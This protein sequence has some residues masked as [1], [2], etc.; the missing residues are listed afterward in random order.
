M[1]LEPEV[2]VE[3][4]C[5]V[6]LDDED[7]CPVAPAT[8]LVERLGR[9]RRVSLAPVLPQAH[10]WRACPRACLGIERLDENMICKRPGFT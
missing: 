1:A 2:I 5:V 4:P 7:W 3:P 6:P 9:L 8:F 10:R